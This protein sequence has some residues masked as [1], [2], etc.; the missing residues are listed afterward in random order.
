MNFL[1]LSPQAAYALLASVALLIVLMYWLRPRPLRVRVASNLIWRTLDMAQRPALDRWRWWFSLMLALA[2]GLSIAL[3]LTR[4]QAP[5]LGGIAQRV[6]LVLDNSPSMAARGEDRISRWEHALERARRII[7]SAGL[8]SEVMVLDTLGRTDTPEWVSRETA[9]AKLRGLAVRTSG[10]ARMPLVP[11]GENIAAHLLTDGV[12]HLDVSPDMAVESVFA[13][14]DNIAITAFDAKSS[15]H[16]PTRYQALVQVF[17]ASGRPKQVRL[18]LTGENGFAL[19]RVLNLSAGATINQT[20]DVTD[21]ADG[22]LRA[23]VRA[24]GDGFQLDD[25]AYGVVVPHRVKRVLLVTAGNRHLQASL[26]R[27]P[28][29]ALTVIKPVQIRPAADYDANVFDRFAPPERPARGALLFRP[30]P[31]TWLPAFGR[32]TTN[33]VI[34]RWDQSHPLAVNV[35]WRGVHMQSAALAKLS[36]HDSQTDVVL[37]S[38]ASEGVLVAAGGAASRGIT[39]ARWIAVGFALDDSNFA[40]QPAFPVFLG[41]ALAWL[42]A[43]AET[44]THGLGYVE[45]PYAN[46]KV[47][48]LDGRPVAAVSVPGATVFDAVRPGVFTVASNAGTTQVVANV[49]DP[50]VSDVNRSRF[51]GESVAVTPTSGLPRFG[52]EPWV[53]LLALAVALL[54]LEWLAYTRHRTV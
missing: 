11:A 8:A 43:G 23:E 10:V 14:A 3:A 37:A 5:A 27:L 53:V 32:T 22:V 12:A 39:G 28:G 7:S 52:F 6:V 9:L 16:D 2:T 50:Q 47:T 18:A 4:P 42:T 21:Y 41:S 13:P 24:Q 49:I 17:N 35:S 38:G 1:A 34:T 54:A 25:V 45:M 51:A 36:A 48:G 44:L 20:L 29:V 31:V 26:G 15:L 46:A 30:P 19:E 33:P 40:M